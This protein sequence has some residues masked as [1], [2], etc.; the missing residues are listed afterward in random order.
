MSKYHTNTKL[1]LLFLIH[2]IVAVETCMN[3]IC[4]ILRM[5]T[6]TQKPPITSSST[7]VHYDTEYPM[8]M[9]NTNDV[10]YDTY[11]E[12]KTFQATNANEM[13]QE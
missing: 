2:T 3:K 11:V 8:T 13:K 9:Q 5:K 7:Y 10:D 12:G 4:A 6:S 1:C